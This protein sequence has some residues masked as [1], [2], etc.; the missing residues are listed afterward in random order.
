M[1]HADPDAAAAASAP[2]LHERVAAVLDAPEAARAAAGGAHR[3]GSAT[4]SVTWWD[5]PDW[6]LHRARLAFG[7]H[8]TGRAGTA[9]L[10]SDD[11]AP[12]A[13]AVAGPW[14]GGR[15]PVLPERLPA[16]EPAEVVVRVCGLRA[17]LPLVTVTRSVTSLNVL[18]ERDKTVARLRVVE[19]VAALEVAPGARYVRGGAARARPELAGPGWVEVEALRGYARQAAVLARLLE[20]AGLPVVAVL[21]GAPSASTSAPRPA[22]VPAPVPAPTPGPGDVARLLRAAGLDPGRRLPR[23]EASLSPSAPAPVAVATMLLSFLD[24]V[25][26]TADGVVDDVDTEFLHDLRIAVRRSR[27]A[28]KLA[29]DVLP[30]D[31]VAAFGPRLKWMGDVTTPLRDLDVHLL[32]LPAAAAG[33]RGFDADDLEPFAR[34]LRARR[35]AE[36]RRLARIVRSATWREVCTQ[37]RAALEGVLERDAGPDVPRTGA[38]AAAKVARADRRVTRLGAAIT[39]ASPAED[40]HTLRK[41]AKE[42]RYV[43]ELFAPVLDAGAVRALVGDLKGFQD[44]LGRF[45]DAEVQRDAVVELAG[46]LAAGAAQAGQPVPVRALLALGELAGRLALDQASARESFEGRFATYLEPDARA[47]VAALTAPPGPRGSRKGKRR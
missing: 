39:P 47:H 13:L 37:W 11:V 34:F 24:D 26:A 3:S 30:A 45:Q 29:A 32:D 31:L 43:L 16:G 2:P 17:L 15:G 4:V 10:T 35:V 27:S 41:R 44:V 12:R 8:G 36:Q 40:L 25:E 1:T 9:V 42:L 46:Q 6:R 18:D 20:Q 14:V 21:P 28:V 19:P 23:R 22:T 38:L 5:T 7:V 33:L